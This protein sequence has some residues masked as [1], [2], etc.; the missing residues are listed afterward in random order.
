MKTALTPTVLQFLVDEGFQICL[1][2]TSSIFT[3]KARFCTTLTPAKFDSMPDRSTGLFDNFFA[4]KAEPVVMAQGLYDTIVLV[5]MDTT[6][7]QAYETKVLKVKK[8]K[9]AAKTA[10]KQYDLVA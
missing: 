2:K 4:I 8:R 7:W 6:T 5:D 9:T 1:S 10:R 3:K